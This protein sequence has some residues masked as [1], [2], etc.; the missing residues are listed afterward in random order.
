M[1]AEIFHKN[2]VFLDVLQLK[3]GVWTRAPAER[4]RGRTRHTLG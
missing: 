1:V 3:P 2:T 4:P